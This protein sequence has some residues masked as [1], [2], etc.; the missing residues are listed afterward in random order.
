MIGLLLKLESVPEFRAAFNESV[1]DYL[2][3]CKELGKELQKPYKGVFNVRV[4]PILHRKA[5]QEAYRRGITLNEIV[6][7][8]IEQYLELEE[9]YCEWRESQRIID[10][11]RLTFTDTR[12]VRVEEYLQYQSKSLEPYIEV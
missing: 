4:N 3:L 1:D 9:R 7:E 8:A 6:C 2:E 5:V 10:E 11:P 12:T